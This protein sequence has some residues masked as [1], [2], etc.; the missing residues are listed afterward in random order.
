RP[1]IPSLPAILPQTWPP[2][3]TAPLASLPTRVFTIATNVLTSSFLTANRF[4]VSLV[5]SQ[6]DFFRVLVDSSV[7]NIWFLS[8]PLSASSDEIDARE[9]IDG[10]PYRGEIPKSV[11][12]GQSGREVQFN[13]AAFDMPVVSASIAEAI[14]GI[15]PNDVELFPVSIRGVS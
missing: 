12:I 2:P 1:P 7:R 6:S 13:F 3:F 4:Q 9:F 11:L 14:A 5:N 8:D 10:F 15:A